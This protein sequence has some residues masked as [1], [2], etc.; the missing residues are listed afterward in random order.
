MYGTCKKDA[1]GCACLFSCFKQGHFLGAKRTGAEEAICLGSSGGEPDGKEEPMNGTKMVMAGVLGAVVAVCGWGCSAA[2]EYMEERK[3]A[4]EEKAAK[5]KQEAEEAERARIAEEREVRREA[6][7]REDTVKDDVPLH[8]SNPSAWFHETDGTMQ[9]IRKRL[10]AAI[11][12]L[13]QF[14]ARYEGKAETAAEKSAG[15]PAL[16]EKL[17]AAKAAGKWPVAVGQFFLDSEAKCDAEIAEV[18]A[19]TAKTSVSSV[20]DEAMLNGV[21]DAAAKARVRLR[22]FDDDY[23]EFTRRWDMFRAG[24]LD[25]VPDELKTQVQDAMAVTKRFMEEWESVE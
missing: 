23:A 3:A 13:D 4:R 12:K 22:E 15:Y 5:A 10:V 14:V 21:K 24:R 25:G 20:K 18:K 6:Q 9:E 1:H 17:E 2:D 16:L 7:G 11:S 8:A 19:A